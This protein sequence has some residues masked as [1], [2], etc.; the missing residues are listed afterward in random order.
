MRYNYNSFGNLDQL[1]GNTLIQ[2][3]QA[4]R[5]GSIGRMQPPGT[6]YRYTVGPGNYAAKP[7]KGPQ[8][9]GAGASSGMP[10]TQPDSEVYREGPARPVAGQVSASKDAS[11]EADIE[12]KTAEGKPAASPAGNK[13][14]DEYSKLLKLNFNEENLL[15]GLVMAE[16]LGKPKC[17]RRGR[18]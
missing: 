14:P 13:A 18:W 11:A 15:S 9:A 17:L 6:N 1:V 7:D 16:V 4:I 12:V 2:A 3:E 5:S 10:G 8:Q